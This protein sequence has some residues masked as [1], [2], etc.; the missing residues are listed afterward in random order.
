MA[1]LSLFGHRVKQLRQELALSQ[2][3]FA[4]KIGVTASA[5]SAYEKGQKNPSVNV[6]IEIA[7][8]YHISLDWL[9]GLKDVEN[10]F[11]PDEYTPFDLISALSGLIQL[12]SNGLL[13]SKENTEPVVD[14]LVVEGPLQE[15]LYEA[16]QIETLFL[17]GALSEKT[18][19][20]CIDELIAN[21]AET[22]KQSRKDR[23]LKEKQFD[24]FLGLGPLALPFDEVLK[25]INPPAES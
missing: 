22:L 14:L 20:L 12:Q 3:D 6:A 23:A 25:Q 2:R 11:E 18:Y 7:T 8:A 4:E 19:N 5:L 16:S 1:D 21:T 13:Q 15:F 17:N 9:C 10:K 24:N